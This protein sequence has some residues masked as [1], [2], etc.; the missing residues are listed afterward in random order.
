MSRA[1]GDVV[2]RFIAKVDWPTDAAD[3]WPWTAYRDR[4]GYGA[5]SVEGRFASAHRTAY[6]LAKGPI[7]DGLQIDHLCRNRRCVNP[8]HM[9]AVTPAENTRRSGLSQSSLN[10]L[11]THCASGHLFDEE[12]TYVYR[13][14]GLAGL[15]TAGTIGRRRSERSFGLGVPNR[16]DPLCV[17]D[18]LAARE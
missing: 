9:E 14:S 7:P 13:E 18:G 12:N 17:H 15:V 2:D 1:R 8:D 11:K 5:F 6:Q 3:C 4:F 10:A 16:V